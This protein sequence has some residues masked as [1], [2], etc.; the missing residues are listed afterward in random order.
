MQ[1]VLESTY[2]EVVASDPD[3]ESNTNRVG[4]QSYVPTDL[5]QRREMDRRAAS[6]MMRHRADIP[7]T[8]EDLE[9]PIDQPEPIKQR[10]NATV[11]NR[12]EQLERERVAGLV[13]PK[14]ESLAVEQIQ[15]IEKVATQFAEQANDLPKVTGSLASSRETQVAPLPKAADANRQRHW[16]RQPD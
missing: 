15:Q 8:Y 2:P 16:I 9:V 13:M 11:A 14:L 4:R 6:Q 1:S 12:A 10:F 5:A 3:S 7:L